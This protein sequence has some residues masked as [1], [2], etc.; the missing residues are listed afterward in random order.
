MFLKSL[1]KRVILILVVF[2]FACSPSKEDP[3]APKK[4]SLEKTLENYRSVSSHYEGIIEANPSDESLKVSLARFYYDFRDYQKS[5]ELLLEI[6]TQQAQELLAKVLVKLKDYDHAIEICEQLK[7]NSNDPEYFYLYG[8]LLEEK[9]LFPKALKIYGKAKDPFKELAQGRIHAIKTKKEVGIPEK[10]SKL[11]KEAKDFIVK[12]KDDA[13]VILLVDEDILI[14]DDN[15]SVS[16]IHVVEKILK[17]RGKKLA[18]VEVGYDSTY[19]RVELEFARTIT[20]DEET[21]YVGE[22]NTRDVS[23]YLNYPLYSNSRAFIVSMP[24]VDVGAFIE[25]KIKIYSSKLVA[26]DKFSFI[27]RLRE[28]HPVFKAKFKLIL[29][30]EQKA[31]FKFINQ[32]YAKEINLKPEII[33]KNNKIIYSWRFDEI[34]PIIPEPYMPPTSYINPAVLI[35]NF[36]SWDQ[37][38]EWW[39]SL[40]QDKLNLNDSAKS[41]VQEI[42]KD[43]SSDFDKAKKLHEYVAKNIRYVAVEYGDSGHEPH[44]VN[45]VLINRYGDCKDQAILLVAMLR[46]ANLEAYPVLI[47]TNSA[48]PVFKDFA[49][50]NFNH[51]ISVVKIGK[52]LIFMDPTAETIGFGRIPL[53]DQERPVMVFYDDSWQILSTELDKENEVVYDMS[54]DVD[55]KENSLVKRSVLTSG[56]FASSYRWYIKYTHPEIVKEDIQKK[57]R[58]ISTFSE[59]IDYDVKNIDNF[60]L[61]PILTYS[62]RADKFFNPA[63][64]LR[65]I[66][67]LSQI[68]FDPKLIS[69]Q[70]RNFPIDLEALSSETARVRINI[71]SSF[72]I[73]YLPKSFVL[74]NLWFKLGIEYKS[75]LDW[76]NFYQKLDIKKRFISQAEYE[77]FKQQLQKA[78]YILREE[79]ILEKIKK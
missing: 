27:Y 9:N 22:E 15:T 40:Y 2:V 65:I 5:K 42:I 23:R 24:S 49:S 10:V 1:A 62:F 70:K 17:E 33:T 38:Y 26:E 78:M 79:I 30:K 36:S 4:R 61:N 11:F 25:Y 14:K 18:E 58:Q 63:G 68:D 64:N 44:E 60:E 7:D 8:K 66:S 67:S 32:E 57:M 16:T 71:P 77:E 12:S 45:E 41:L 51:A 37:V 56:F 73:K 72:R 52:D 46:E 76:I 20:K 6:D 54:V 39:R 28:K 55:S 19:E 47:P 50:L 31:F 75:G 35:S 3:K 74:D 69:K 53:S 29:P 13:A 43:V 21:I 34:K 48:Y 59:L